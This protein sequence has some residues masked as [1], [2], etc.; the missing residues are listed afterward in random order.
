MKFIDEY[1]SPALVSGLLLRIKKKA[2][3]LS[4]TIT[5]MEVCG[6][7]TTAIGRFGIRRLLPENIRLVSGP[8]CPV[9]V[10]STQDIDQALW[11]A[12]RPD[13]LFTSYGDLLRVPGSHGNS[14]E[15]IRATGAQVKTVHSALE[16]LTLAQTHPDQKVVFMGIGFETTS[17]TVAA[18]VLKAEKLNLNNFSIFCSHKLMPPVMRLLLDEQ[19]LALDGFLCPGHVSTIIG[20]K[21]YEFITDS[22]RAAAVTGFEPVDILEGI[23]LILEELTNGI[24][25]V[26]L[27]Y[28][29]GVNS[30][31]NPKARELLHEVFEPATVNWRGLGQ[32]PDSG[33]TL[34]KEF[35]AFDAGCHFVI[36]EIESQTNSSC[37]CGEVLRGLIEPAA[38][39]MFGSTCTP[40]NP[41]GPCMVSNEGSCAAAF[42]YPAH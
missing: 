19:E 21:V 4:R 39:K 12:S 11:L 14:L 13:T 36:P 5:I 38:C 9:C 42:R 27:Q 30:Q 28:Q 20:T 24:S 40:N 31:G 2:A 18:A 33:L 26:R 7:H 37:R 16:A 1:R 15:K 25:K 41:F 22:G 10:T 3:L 29:R 8:G 17:P 23:Y 35:S 32:I 34:R 6:S